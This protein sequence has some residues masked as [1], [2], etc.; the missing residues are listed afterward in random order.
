M[1][2]T[3]Y[4]LKVYSILFDSKPQEESEQLGLALGVRWN[5]TG[6]L[7]GAE[8]SDCCVLSTVATMVGQID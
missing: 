3:S 7:S 1:E 5:T 4:I 6:G 8:W 2:F